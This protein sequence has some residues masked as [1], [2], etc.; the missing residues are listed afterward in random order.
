[1]LTLDLMASTWQGQKILSEIL[2]ASEDNVLDGLRPVPEPLRADIFSFLLLLQAEGE[3]LGDPAVALGNDGSVGL[4]FSDDQQYVYLDF[5]A[6]RRLHYYIRVGAEVLD[7]AVARP[8]RY[9]EAA[10]LLRR[11]LVGATSATLAIEN[12]GEGYGEITTSNVSQLGGQVIDTIIK[13]SHRPARL[14]PRQRG[15][16]SQGFETELLVC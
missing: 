1:M 5:T 2:S 14:D 16:Y 6:D 13:I 15:Q 9:A 4:L 8:T 12:S 7:E 10:E 11:F 3:L